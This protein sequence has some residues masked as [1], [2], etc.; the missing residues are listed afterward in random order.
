M[1]S[2]YIIQPAACHHQLHLHAALAVTCLS[3][4]NRD[5]EEGRLGRIGAVLTSGSLGNLCNNH[6]HKY[7]I[8]SIEAY[9][10]MWTLWALLDTRMMWWKCQYPQHPR[11][12]NKCHFWLG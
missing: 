12:V 2:E 1:R 8:A 6:S 3:L 4:V 10:D 7:L 5:A 9:M 11:L